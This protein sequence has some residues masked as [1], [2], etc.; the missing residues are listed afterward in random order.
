MSMYQHRG[1]GGVPPGN[2]S[3]LNEL[4]DNVRAEFE[5]Q[6]RQT[7]GL[8]HQSKSRILEA[9]SLACAWVS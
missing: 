9:S 7:E 5:N 2:S 4:L 1:M 3:R 8:D 6:A